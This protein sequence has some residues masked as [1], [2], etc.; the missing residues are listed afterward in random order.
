MFGKSW[1]NHPL[2]TW[3]AALSLAGCPCGAQAAEW[4]FEFTPYIW[5]SAMKGGTQAGQLPRV[6]VDMSFGDIVNILDAGLMGA[7]EARK[8]RWG[9]LLDAIYMKVSDGGTASRTGPGPVGAT[10]TA[11]A[12]VEFKQTT[13]AAAAAYRLSEGRSPVDL[14]GGFRYLKVDV[15]ARIDATLFGRAGAEA[16]SAEKSWADPYVGLR[17]QHPLSER[18]TLMGYADV[19]G[20][21]VE[22]DFTW[23]AA[24]GASYEFSKTVSGKIGF[25]QIAVDY[26]KGGFI[27]DMK[28]QGFYV[29]AG[30]RF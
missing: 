23:Q 7:F 11:H 18:W 6:D 25:R 5:A 2:T 10:A 13:L 21:G 8:G 16:R 4:Q 29:G 17:V 12:D 19:G 14:V 3:A 22:S 28:Y 30:F 20:F 27:F 1:R 26:D 9:V 15:G 24:V